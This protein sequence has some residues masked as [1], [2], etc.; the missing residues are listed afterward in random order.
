MNLFTNLPE[1]TENT[2]KIIN[3]HLLKS[4]L[5]I[6]KEAYPDGKTSLESADVLIT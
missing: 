5:A 6:L 4:D 3:T 1:S 2:I